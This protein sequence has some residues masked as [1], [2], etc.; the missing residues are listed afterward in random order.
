M[1]V[2]EC[3]TVRSVR[4][5]VGCPDDLAPLLGFIPD[6]LCEIAGRTRNWFAS[7]QIGKPRSH[8]G[9]QERRI[10]FCIELTDDFGRGVLGRAYP[11]PVGS[12]IARHEFTYSRKVRQFFQ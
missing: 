8:L 7:T 1:G 2:V 3:L 5:D 9:V 6:Q 10:D 11:E 4:L 12:L